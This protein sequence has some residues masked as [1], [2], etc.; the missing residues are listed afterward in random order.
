[1]GLID[2]LKWLWDPRTE[3]EKRYET[4]PLRQYTQ[5]FLIYIKGIDEPFARNLI[6][7]DV[8]ADGWMFRV[9]LERAVS[10][11][12]A[13]RGVDGVEIDDTWY[14]PDMILRIEMGEH[15]VKEL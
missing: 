3:E 11:W 5:K 10:K 4:D 13:Q 8:D 14:P 12:L 15:T 6:F 1:M 7:T 9:N 2:T